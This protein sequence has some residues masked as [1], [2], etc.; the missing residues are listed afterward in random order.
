MLITLA[1][2]HE[3]IFDRYYLLTGYEYDPKTGKERKARPSLYRD[4]ASKLRAKSTTKAQ[5][6]EAIP[7]YHF[8]WSD[9]LEIAFYAF[10][11]D[12]VGRENADEW[13]LSLD[14]EPAIGQYG[15]LIEKCPDFSKALGTPLGRQAQRKIET[16]GRHEEWQRMVNRVAAEQ[17]GID[18]R[19]ACKQVALELTKKKK[20]GRPA[21]AGTIRK[22]TKLPKRSR[23]LAK[24]PAH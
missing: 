24:L 20:K 10:I 3:K 19:R 22:V 21:D 6:L 5:R 9:E 23:T 14:W 18:H 8:V 7:P 17:P 13:E 11:D 15:K 16:E 2:L 1:A 12:I 4:I